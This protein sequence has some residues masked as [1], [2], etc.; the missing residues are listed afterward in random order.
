MRDGHIA[1]P[2]TVPDQHRD[3]DIAQR[4]APPVPQEH[5]LPGHLVAPQRFGGVLGHD[6]GD[7]GA[8]DGAPVAFGQFPPES[9]L[10]PFRIPGCLA[11]SQDQQPRS[12]V[13]QLEPA[14]GS[15]EHAPQRGGPEWRDAADHADGGDP[16]G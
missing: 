8:L 7:I 13:G 5:H 9:G 4:E 10:E 15:G 2:F 16:L 6:L 1:V 3:L 14:P 12:P 11:G